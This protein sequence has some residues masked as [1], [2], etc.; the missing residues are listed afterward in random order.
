MKVLLADSLPETTIDHLTAMGVQVVN[1]PKLKAEELAGAIDDADVLVVRSTEVHADCISTAKNLSLIIRAGAGV[2]NI[3]MKAA[4][5]RGIYVSNCPG[6][7]SIAVAELAMGLLLAI[8]RRIPDNV[9]DLRNAKW[10]KSEYSKADGIFGKT[11]GVIGAGQIGKEFIKRAK[12]FGMDVV[13]WSRS[14]TKEKAETL[15]ARYSAT[16]EELIPQCDVISVHLALKP[17]TKKII[18][19]EMIAMMRP[20]TIFLNTSRW[21][22]VDEP[23]L[24][25][26]AKSGTIRVGADVFSG[27][28]EDK[29]SPFTNGLASLPNVY[30]THH[31]GASTE[32][33]QNAIA[34]E[35]VAIIRQYKERGTVK[36]W[37]N[38]AKVTAAK[39]QMVIR[40][41]DKPGVLANV[42][43]D[44]KS[45]EINI[46][47][48]ENLIF[49][50]TQTACCTLK[51]DA[52]PPEKT[53]QS[54]SARTNEVIQAQLVT[55]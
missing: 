28:P 52:Q 1:K 44:L 41:Y 12:A 34:D 26:A 37:V 14:L 15:G 9:T 6:K 5:A 13:V 47:E 48:V 29:T 36:N 24:L 20:R 40:H 49:E 39:Y 27:E 25:E 46:Q 22:V 23:A 10:N 33:A 4:N 31:I 7:N 35:T 32:Q 21:E 42:F 3:D 38:K 50:G 30:G 17:E 53:L 18:T 11:V 51:L 43:N 54:I 45:A 16:I 55:L 2:N 19:K 8:D